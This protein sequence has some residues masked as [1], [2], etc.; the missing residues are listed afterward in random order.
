MKILHSFSEVKES[1]NIIK[2]CDFYKKNHPLH[3]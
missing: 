1:L 2:E 3:F